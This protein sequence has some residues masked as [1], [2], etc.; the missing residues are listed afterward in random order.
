M[1]ITNK[2]ISEIK[3]GDTVLHDGE[4]KTVCANNIKRCDL[5]GITLFGD[6][7]LLGNKPVVI[8][9]IEGRQH[10]QERLQRLPH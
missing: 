5:M 10:E 3:T 7:Y 8:V 9:L 6:S 4:L 2:H 1:N